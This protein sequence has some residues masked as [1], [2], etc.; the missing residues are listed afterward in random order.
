MIIYKINSVLSKALAIL[1]LT[2]APLM[3]AQASG[4]VKVYGRHVGGQVLYNYQIINNSPN[5]IA[6]ARIGW[7]T[8][9][10]NNPDNDG[11]ELAS[12]PAGWDSRVHGAALPPG[13]FT[14]PTGWGAEVVLQEETLLRAIE[15]GIINN[16]HSFDIKPGETLTG[17][18]VTL[19]KADS[20]Y[21]SSHVLMLY[22]D[23]YPKNRTVPIER[24]D[25]TSPSLTVTISPAR[26]RATVGD[27]VTVTAT[28]TTTDDYDPSPEIKLESIT[29]NEPFAAGDV[30]GAVIGTDDRQF[31]LRD[32]KVP[33]GSAGRIYTITYLATDASGNRTTK[34][35]T[36]SVK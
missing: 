5:R 1:C 9:N 8:Q 12:L 14:V 2:M 33:K 15:F 10:D 25:T 6:A 22:S 35:A 34:S 11:P 32:V 17:L 7:D 18:S 19:P 30:V 24:L 31:Q 21:L 27:L 29:A 3:L 16:D 28:V 36:V 20:S 4:I 13:T 26:L 23:G